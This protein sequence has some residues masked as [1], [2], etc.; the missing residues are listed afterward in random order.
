ME[1]P[2]YFCPTAATWRKPPNDF[3]YYLFY[4]FLLSSSAVAHNPV[5]CYPIILLFPF[6]LF[7]LYYPLI[8]LLFIISIVF[9]SPS[10]CNYPIFYYPIIPLSSF[11]LPAN[12]IFLTFLIITACS[13]F[14]I[15]FIFSSLAV[16]SII[17]LYPS[18]LSS[19]FC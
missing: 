10:V 4:F 2:H 6:C 14:F 7:R 1:W 16:Q 3:T 13:Y 17:I 18:I 12:F 19:S 9:L 5:S 11:R 8:F 15:S